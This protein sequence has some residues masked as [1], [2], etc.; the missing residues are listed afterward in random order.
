MSN[1]EGLGGGAV[2]IGTERSVQSGWMR[3]DNAT[4]KLRWRVRSLQRRFVEGRNIYGTLD[5]GHRDNERRV[6][7]LIK[8]SLGLRRWSKKDNNA[9]S[10]LNQHPICHVSNGSSA[11]TEQ[12]SDK[13]ECLVG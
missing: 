11:H 12:C 4:A 10:N 5:S 3:E 8:R 1:I 13:G 7:T 2:R 9:Y 6:Y